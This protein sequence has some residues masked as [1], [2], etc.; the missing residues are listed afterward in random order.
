MVHLC[1]VFDGLYANGQVGAIG[2]RHTWN[3]LHIGLCVCIYACVCCACVCVHVYVVH[4]LCSVCV[5][6]C[7]CVCVYVCVQQHLTLLSSHWGSTAAH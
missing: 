1:H 6:V 3:Q 7:V 2:L 4:V 5:C